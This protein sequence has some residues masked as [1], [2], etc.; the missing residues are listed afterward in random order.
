MTDDEPVEQIDV[1]IDNSD[2]TY[3]VLLEGPD[4]TV[5]AEVPRMP[6]N[7]TAYQSEAE[8]EREF[9]AQLCRQGY[10]QVGVHDQDGLIANL[11]RQVERLNGFI[12]ADF[13]HRCIYPCKGIL[14]YIIMCKAWIMTGRRY[15]SGKHL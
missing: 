5:C 14:R 4:A 9:I 3:S 11:R 15:H 7:S 12:F 8:L 13:I 6:S 2:K 10:E 1:V